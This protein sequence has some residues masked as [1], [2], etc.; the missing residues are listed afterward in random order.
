MKL[1]RK[2]LKSI[3][4]SGDRTQKHRYSSHLFWSLMWV[5]I[6]SL[7]RFAY[8]DSKPVWSDE[9][10][11][12]V[13][14]LGHSFHTIP[15]DEIISIQT[16]LEPLRIDSA[17]GTNSAI[18][19][20]M[21]ESTHPPLYFVLTHWWFKLFSHDGDLVSIWLARSLSAIF[22]ILAIPAMFALGWLVFDSLLAGQMAAALMAVSPYGIY[23]AQEV[24]HYTLAILWVIASLACFVVTVR[25]W[26]KQQIPSRSLI[27]VWILTNSLGMATHYF[28]G[29]NLLAQ[30]LALVWLWWQDIKTSKGFLPPIWRRISLAVLGTIASSLIWVFRWQYFPDR[31][32]TEWIRYEFSPNLE[33]LAPIGRLLTWILT[34]VVLPPVEGTYLWISILAIA[35]LLPVVFWLIKASWQYLQTPSPFVLEMMVKFTSIAVVLIILF[36]YILRKDLTLAA[37]FQ[38]F[39]FPAILLIIAGLLSQR[40]QSTR[41]K[42]LAVAV[43][44]AGCLGG[45]TVV[46]N[47]GFQKSDRPDL[48][49]PAILEVQQQHRSR[50]PTVV[51]TVHKTHEQTGEMMGLAWEWQ[52]IQPTLNDDILTSPPRFL[53]L[54]KEDE[55]AVASRNL[56]RYLDKSTRPF[57]LWLVN[58]S[59]SIKLR[60]QNLDSQGCTANQNYHSRVS[61]YS[62]R[63]YHCQ[64]KGDGEMG[65]EVESRALA[66]INN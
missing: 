37:R 25:C 65:R 42:T 44:L 5:I 46:G 54:H 23:L 39:Y 27:L 8:L 11:T 21:N 17:L 61:G 55:P 35:I 14:S 15:L 20:L 34:M 57:D 7:L 30:M 49:V 41:G 10:A 2:H 43:L 64:V 18:A 3:N 62:Y 16:L 58:F 40:W 13:F 6:G 22:G 19:N 38:Y 29:L 28:F 1:I 33:L 31:R 12:I 4:F 9:W 48:L 60:Y 50:I 56:Y 47:Y 59:A 66:S 53:L 32:L 51:A 26:Q 52:K 63:L 36:P 24:R 45:I